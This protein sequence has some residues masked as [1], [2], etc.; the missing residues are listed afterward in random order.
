MKKNKIIIV[1]VAVVILIL[2]IFLIIDYNYHNKSI[3][4]CCDINN[5]CTSCKCSG[6]I[7]K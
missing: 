4:S 6:I 3:C 5:T 1:I 7:F 2:G